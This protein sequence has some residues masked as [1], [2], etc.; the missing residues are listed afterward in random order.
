MS[1]VKHL[2][3]SY[4]YIISRFEIFVRFSKN[5]YQKFQFKFSQVYSIKGLASKANKK[6]IL[7]N[8]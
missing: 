5:L 2:E 3:K 8:V 6:P 7:S 1:F 4:R